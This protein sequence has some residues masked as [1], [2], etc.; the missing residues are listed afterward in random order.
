MFADQYTVQQHARQRHNDLLREA[1]AERLAAAA[2]A[3]GVEVEQ[4]R[5]ARS[6]GVALRLARLLGAAPLRP[7]QSH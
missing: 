1:R 3:N 5:H 4:V 2:S 7:A 6:H